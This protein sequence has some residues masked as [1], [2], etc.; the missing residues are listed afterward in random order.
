MRPMVYKGPCAARA[1]S[2]RSITAWP[3]SRKRMARSRSAMSTGAVSTSRLAVFIGIPPN[4]LR[5][6][7]WP[8]RRAPRRRAGAL[9]RLLLTSPRT[10]GL[11]GLPRLA[12][13]P[14]G[15][16]RQ[17]SGHLSERGRVRR[18]VQDSP[19]RVLVRTPQSLLP[20]QSSARGPVAV[21][22]QPR[23]VA[24]RGVKVELRS[25]YFQWDGGRGLLVREHDARRAARPA[26]PSRGR[27]GRAALQAQ[28]GAAPGVVESAAPGS[29]RGTNSTRWRTSWGLSPGRV[30]APSTGGAC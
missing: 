21:V 11:R 18:E 12:V 9:M 14:G 30:A 17:S 28:E 4:A 20:S 1:M 7:L 19:P 29:A 10:S 5:W 13:G 25:W 15:R 27:D 23:A 3:G 24:A 6:S 2:T 16:G 22:R 26:V 8:G